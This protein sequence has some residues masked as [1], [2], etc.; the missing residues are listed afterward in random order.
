LDDDT[1]VQ[2]TGADEESTTEAEDV[3]RSAEET[4]STESSGE[5]TTS[6]V[7]DSVEKA[8]LADGTPE[9]KPVPYS[10]YRETNEARIR[11]EAELNALRQ[12]QQQPAVNQPVNPQ[13]EAIKEQLKSLGFV[14]R[15]E[16]ETELRRQ[17]ED[18]DLA[19]EVD[20][21]STRYD[22][23]DGLPKFDKSTVLKYALDRQVGDL[24]AAYQLMN[25]KKILDAQI[26]A[27]TSQSRGVQVESSTGK[28]REEATTS[29]AD[30][31][32]AIAK[33]DKAS[34]RTYLKRAARPQ[35]GA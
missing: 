18:A 8:N 13:T 14:T 32:A 4:A 33:G 12:S 15:E 20:R 16:Q 25:Q 3:N 23:K 34:L 9:D 30:L 27:A 22:G 7:S 1:T 29:S 31:K 17:R 6:E 35:R 11:A 5:E 2:D 28:G 24:E 19:R 21:L 10:R 26:K